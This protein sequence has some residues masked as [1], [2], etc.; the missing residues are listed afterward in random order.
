MKRSRRRQSNRTG[1]SW[2]WR[3][4][5]MLALGIAATL[6]SSIA[7]QETMARYADIDGCVAGCPVSAAGWPLP[8][9]VDYP[10]SSPAREASLTGAVL[11]IDR[12]RLEALALDLLLWTALSAILLTL[13]GRFRR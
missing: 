5:G 8:Y 2:R 10:G 9:I 7:K 12:W 6:A 4:A 1:R 3:I 11:G 13:L